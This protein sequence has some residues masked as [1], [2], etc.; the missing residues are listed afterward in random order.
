M[1]TTVRR[2]PYAYLPVE[3]S[4]GRV[5]RGRIEAGWSD[6]LDRGDFTLGKRVEGFEAA[7]ASAV[8][9][10]HAVGLRSGTDALALAITGLGLGHQPHARQR[11]SP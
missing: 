7:F 4:R 2:G 11:M 1:T 3:L 5:L 9:A 6:L 10:P 8:G